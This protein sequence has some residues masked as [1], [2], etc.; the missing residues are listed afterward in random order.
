MS[1]PWGMKKYIR[2]VLQDL[3]G[4]RHKD[5]VPPVPTAPTDAPTVDLN[6]PPEPVLPGDLNNQDLSKN[7]LERTRQLD[8][9]AQENEE[10][11]TS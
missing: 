1:P 5:Y 2:E 11:E 9:Q 10:R 7:S 4:K 6:A 3:T 8:W